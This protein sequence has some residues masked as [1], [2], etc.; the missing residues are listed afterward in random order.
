MIKE[1]TDQLTRQTIPRKYFSGGIHGYID[2]EINVN[3]A[4]SFQAKQTGAKE[5]DLAEVVVQQ[6]ANYRRI[7]LRGLAVL[8]TVA[9]GH[10]LKR[11]YS[12]FL[13]SPEN[14]DVSIPAPFGKMDF[15]SIPT[16]PGKTEEGNCLFYVQPTYLWGETQQDILVF[17][18]RNQEHIPNYSYMKAAIKRMTYEKAV[19]ILPNEDGYRRFNVIFSSNRVHP[20][21][22]DIQPP[23]SPAHRDR[24]G[25][26]IVQNPAD[27]PNAAMLSVGEEITPYNRYLLG[28]SLRSIPAPMYQEP[29]DFEIVLTPHVPKRHA[30]TGIFTF[31]L[32]EKAIGRSVTVFEMTIGDN[33]TIASNIIRNPE[34]Q[35]LIDLIIR[36]IRGKSNIARQE[37]NFIRDALRAIEGRVR[38]SEMAD[39]QG[40]RELTPASQLL[41]DLMSRPGSPFGLPAQEEDISAQ[42]A[43]VLGELELLPQ[44]MLGRHEAIEALNKFI[45]YLGNFT[46]QAVPVETGR[47][48]KIWLATASFALKARKGELINDQSLEEHL[49]EI[50]PLLSSDQA[51]ALII[52]TGELSVQIELGYTSRAMM[53]IPEKVVVFVLASLLLQQ[54]GLAQAASPK[55][56]VAAGDKSSKKAP[57]FLVMSHRDGTLYYFDITGNTSKF[58]IPKEVE[59]FIRNFKEPRLDKVR[60]KVIAASKSPGNRKIT[61]LFGTKVLRI[62]VPNAPK[63]AV[64]QAQTAIPLGGI[65]MN[66]ANLAMLIKRDGQGMP[67]PVSQQNLDNIHINGLV[68]RILSIRSAAD[69]S[70]FSS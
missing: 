68:P 23:S 5:D 25:N 32:R 51:M 13:R 69:L 28:K 46:G 16:G 15:Y 57:F 40:R 30:K 60:E 19:E 6:P 7:F 44:G 8:G 43:Q 33:K 52:L 1:D 18:D 64:N 70:I 11:N 67:L 14:Y 3:K 29:E 26:F 9:A 49:L 2:T 24:D 61:D 47:V 27:Q 39:L 48:A 42:A 55:A 63:P 50:A 53:G 65:D 34:F 4:M 45:E 35:S 58:E 20:K 41:A 17:L 37:P 10:M 62:T 21:S 22:P 36:I 31:E 59:V 54:N 12:F 56:P 38:N 66:S